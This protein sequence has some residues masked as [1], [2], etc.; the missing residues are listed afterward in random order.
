MKTRKS[1]SLLTALILTAQCATMGVYAQDALDETED[2]AY[3]QE[4]VAVEETEPAAEEPDEADADEDAELLME[5]CAEES[6]EQDE[7]LGAGSVS[8][9]AVYA[10]GRDVAFLGTT[11]NATVADEDLTYT[12]RPIKPEVEVTVTYYTFKPII[13]IPENPVNPIPEEHTEPAIEG[14]DY[15]IAY[16]NNLNAGTAT[17]TITGKGRWRGLKQTFTFTIGQAVFGEDIIADDIELTAKTNKRGDFTAQKPAPAVKW[18]NGTKVAA[19]LYTVAYKYRGY[20]PEEY[21]GSMQVP[22]VVKSVTQPGAYAFIIAPRNKNYTGTITGNILVK[23]PY[24]H[25]SKATLT[26]NPTKYV[27]TGSEITPAFTVS[28]NKQPLTLGED[29]EIKEIINNVEPGKATITLEGKGG[30]TGTISAN[31]TIVAGKVMTDIATIEI[32]SDAYCYQKGGVTPYVTVK[33]G[34]KVLTAGKDYT[35]AY[36]GIYALSSAKNTPT[37]TVT[38]KGKYKGT[39]KK[40]FQILQQNIK[41]TTITVTRAAGKKA[42]YK[43]PVINITDTNGKKLTSSDYT[44]VANSFTEPDANGIVTFKIQGKGCYSGEKKVSYKFN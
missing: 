27:Y 33:D 14:V 9:E 44:V 26:I 10:G 15:A 29:Y 4:E 42:S 43:R 37:I 28:M 18:A 39:A 13:S 22:Q 38:F 7:S 40:T 34:D 5:E 21:H 25:M 20:D 6:P 24:K 12:G 36:K 1:L 17:G 30:L 19:G 8:E 2:I 31:F 23:N 35:V 41:N 3:E 16:K 32:S 11:F